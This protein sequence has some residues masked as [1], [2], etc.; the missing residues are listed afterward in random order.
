MFTWLHM[1][2]FFLQ[3]H[4]K[5]K[6]TQTC[7]CVWTLWL[8]VELATMQGKSAKLLPRTPYW[9]GTG[10]DPTSSAKNVGGSVMSCTAASGILSLL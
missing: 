8:K 9:S 2:L 7:V 6:Q 5:N 1:L 4:F 3:M 10:S